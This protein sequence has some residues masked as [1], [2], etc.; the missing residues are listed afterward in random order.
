M[1]RT[2]WLLILA[3]LLVFSFSCDSGDD[4]DDD[5]DDNDD[6]DAAGDDDNDNDDSADDDDMTGDDDD[7][8]NDD[9]NDD[10]DNDDND[11]WDNSHR[12]GFVVVGEGF[13][14][15]NVIGTD[16]YNYV[17]ASFSDPAE[18]AGWNPPVESAGDCD[19][20]YYDYD[21]NPD[22]DY[23]NGG[24]VTVTGAAVSPIHL[25]PV[26]YLY[27]YYYQ[28]DYDSTAVGDLFGPGDTIHYS[29]TGNG[30]IPAFS[31]Q[32]DAPGTVTV[33]QPANFDSLI[34]LPTGDL[35]LAWQPGD[36]KW[37]SVAITTVKNN[38]AQSISCLADDEDGSLTVP[39][40]LMADLYG[41]PLS[42]SVTVTRIAVQRASAGGKDLDFE[43]TT[44]RGRNYQATDQ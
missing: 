5:P 2:F 11:D 22:Y 23:Y 32:L 9:D 16:Y 17:S 42:F 15:S 6:D 33:T 4:D 36:G 8:D 7:D 24:T 14:S 1:N 28:A 38:Q 21:N 30:S 43:I 27:G 29:T 13:V 44:Y 25:N 31:G 39:A 35:T 19:R 18:A 3:G 26:A 40:S 34:S 12:W 10:N 20:Y 41:D 37:V